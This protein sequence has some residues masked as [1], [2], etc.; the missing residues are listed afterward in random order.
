MC[1]FPHS[2][3]PGPH[4]VPY[5]AAKEDGE[6]TAQGPLAGAGWGGQYVPTVSP[7]RD[8]PV[9]PSPAW[10]GALC[11]VPGFH[12]GF[13][14]TRVPCS[15]GGLPSPGRR[16]RPLASGQQPG[17]HSVGQNVLPRGLTVWPG[18]VVGCCV[19]QQG[20]SSP[21]L[22][23][24]R[25]SGLGCE[26]ARKESWKVSGTGHS[27]VAVPV[28]APQACECPLR[29]GG[30]AGRAPFHVSHGRGLLL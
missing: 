9:A 2:S 7:G 6:G 28:C 22:R 4:S 29:R 26:G 16:C 3:L 21:R 5:G 8:C 30:S 25:S 23:P 11:R 17:L 1:A 24:R 14:G 13:H 20:L 12:A 15:W 27:G 18:I 10:H 19:K